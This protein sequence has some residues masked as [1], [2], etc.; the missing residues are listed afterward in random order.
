MDTQHV[1]HIDTSEIRTFRDSANDQGPAAELFPASVI[2]SSLFVC[3][4]CILRG[5]RHRLHS[6]LK[7]DAPLDLTLV[8]LDFL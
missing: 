1:D 3:G 7:V 8:Y 5:S 6:L 2:G 4:P